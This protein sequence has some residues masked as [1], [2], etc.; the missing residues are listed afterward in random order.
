MFRRLFGG[1]HRQLQ[2]TATLGHRWTAAASCPHFLG[3]VKPYSVSS[4]GADDPSPLIASSLARSCWLSDR[5]AFSISKKV[6]LDALDKALSVLALLKDYGFDDAHLVR[7][8]DHLPRVLS[9]DVEK[10]LKPKLEFYCGISLVGTPFP[11]ILSANPWLLTTT[12]LP[13]LD[14]L[15]AYDMPDDVILVLLTRY[16]YALLTDTAR[17]NE[18]FDKI[19]KMGI[20]LKKTTFARALGLLAILPKKWEEKV[21]NLRGL[22]WSQ[23]HVLEAFAKQPHVAMVST[24]KTRKI[25]KFLE[26]KL[27]WTPEDIVKYPTVLTLSLEKRMMPRYVVLSIL[28]HKGLIKTGFTGKHFVISSNKFQMEFVTEYQDKAPEI[29]EAY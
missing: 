20:C 21:E 27:G 8:V 13:K 11:E 5:A 12:V 2:V 24:E 16:G 15:R 17:F 26:E 10:T 3:F 29:V 18:A 4:V 14:A 25:V 1:V 19:K 9:M 7:L 23:D 6:Q 22:G 28:R